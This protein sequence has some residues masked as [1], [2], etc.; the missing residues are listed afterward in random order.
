MN[1]QFTAVTCRIIMQ[2][3]RMRVQPVAQGGILAKMGAK[4]ILTRKQTPVVIAVR[5]VR[6]PSVIPA[7]DSMNAV[8]GEQ[9]NSDPIEI[10]M[11]SVQYANVERGKSPVSG[12]VAPAKRAMEKRVAVESMISTYRNVK[13]ARAKWPPAPVMSQSWAARVFWMG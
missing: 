12:S 7:P 9:P 2:P 3:T 13:R 11:A 1:P 8:A 6:P 5:P 10:M 4:K